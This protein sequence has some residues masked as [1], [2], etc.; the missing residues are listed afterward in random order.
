MKKKRKNNFI[1][2]CFLIAFFFCFL[3]VAYSAIYSTMSITGNAYARV[4]ADVRITG[5]RLSSTNNATSSY[6][7]FGKNHV[8]TEVNLANSSSTLNYYVEITNY[9]N[10]D[11]GIYDI[12]G[13]PSGVNYLIKD[14][15]LKDK[16]CDD[17][18]K[19]S[20]F[21]VKTYEITLCAA[22]T[23]E[24][25]IQMNFEF[26]SFYSI[27]YSGIANENYVSS[28][29]DGEDLSVTFINY[30]PNK[31]NVYCDG[32]EI[33]RNQYYYDNNSGQLIFQNVSGN[34][35]IEKA[36][37]TLIDGKT[38]SKKLKDFVNGTTD[39]EYNSTDTNVTYIGVFVDEIP[40]GY[41]K[42]QFFG[43]PS[44]SLSENGRVKAYYDNGRVYIYSVDDI[45]A[46]SYS[47]SLFR[48]YSN[49][50]E[51]NINALN[52]SKVD[53]MGAMFQDLVSLTKLDI[54]QW[55][56]DKV[57]RLFYTFHGMNNLKEIYLPDFDSGK[58]KELASTFGNCYSLESLDLS[59]WNVSNVVSTAG[60]FS[61]CYNLNYLNF[62]GWDTRKIT[63]MSTM[64][65]YMQSIEVLDLSSFNTSNVIDMTRMFG[66]CDNLEKIYVGG[67]W[68][69]SNVISSE[70]MFSN[71]PKLP[72]FNSTVIDVS[73]AYVGDGGYLSK[74]SNFS[75]NGVIYQ[76]EEGMTWVEWVDS[77]FNTGDF[78]IVD[79]PTVNDFKNCIRVSLNGIN[80]QLSYND[81]IN[82]S[83]TYILGGPLPEPS[84]NPLTIIKQSD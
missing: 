59:S 10:V 84:I 79:E 37:S 38:F 55:N 4:D 3:T 11:V 52:T 42:Y 57:Y 40:E 47:Y 6:E 2:I 8:V 80:T 21:V 48:G 50:T 67:G 9:G 28:I 30:I 24:G 39:A 72:N 33:D 77:K 5:F 19:C 29:M 36:E 44:E 46:P 31:V 1:F 83:N 82:G 75:I 61:N 81:L 58:L 51:L 74:L 27:T 12:T 23:Y 34:L 32:I 71:S 15:N 14:Y 45:F 65:R 69:V 43:L 66:Y 60:M 64:F 18:G 16:I 73:K 56:V 53:D 25:V 22:S 26:K 54:S 78:I 70:S 20:N 41:S 17:S 13:L 35:V 63:E 62:D 7:D 68:D 76:Y 49:L